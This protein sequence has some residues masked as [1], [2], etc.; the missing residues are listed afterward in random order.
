M[1]LNN[2][3][4][5][6][7]S[8]NDSNKSIEFNNINLSISESIE[9]NE[10]SYFAQNE[11][12]NK[13][14]NKSNINKLNNNI[15]KNSVNKGE[16][17]LYLKNKSC[18]EVAKEFN[19][20]KNNGQIITNESQA[21]SNI[22]NN[23]ASNTF[24]SLNKSEA[25]LVNNIILDMP[26]NIDLNNN[27]SE[28]EKSK[29]ENNIEP[30]KKNSSEDNNINKNLNEK[31]KPDKF[32]KL[33]DFINKLNYSDSEEK[34]NKSK[35]KAQNNDKNNNS[36]IK[37]PFESEIQKEEKIKF[38][39]MLISNSSLKDKEKELIFN[40]SNKYDLNNFNLRSSE[41]NR[42]E[43][44]LENK[45]LTGSIM[46]INSN[47]DKNIHT[48]NGNEN[49]SNNSSYNDNNFNFIEIDSRNNAQD[50][51]DNL[52]II[53]PGLSLKKDEK[54]DKKEKEIKVDNEIKDINNINDE[55]EYDLNDEKFYKPLN[56]YENKFNLE[57]INPF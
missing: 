43:Y 40:Y 6:K 46:Y 36:Q 1:L 47:I 3:T 17:D 13:N 12:S 33:D 38:N 14:I 5:K 11:K 34:K 25:K 32:D 50:F 2:F 29:E 7:N 37:L 24:N 42:T 54:E 10:S 23:N 21:I 49:Y 48:K 26:I 20:N 41:F 16:M 27:E 9:M 18:K 30:I 44:N 28:K 55:K 15:S 52:E 31:E 35:N 39:N 4:I 53:K 22:I 56:K 45:N 8:S 19:I 51:V 57:Q